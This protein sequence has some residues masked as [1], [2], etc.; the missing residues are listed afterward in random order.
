MFAVVRQYTS[1]IVTCRTRPW[2]PSILK[3]WMSLQ[4]V[5]PIRKKLIKQFAEAIPNLPDSITYGTFTLSQSKH[6]TT[7]ALAHRIPSWPIIG[8]HLKANRRGPAFS[9][10][11]WLLIGRL[12]LRN[13]ATVDPKLA[14]RIIT[15]RLIRPG[16]R[17]G[18]AKVKSNR[19]L[20][21]GARVRCQ[22]QWNR[23]TS[24]V[25][26]SSRDSNKLMARRSWRIK[27]RV[28]LI[29]S[30]RIVKVRIFRYHFETKAWSFSGW[31]SNM[32][33][34]ACDWSGLEYLNDQ[35]VIG[36]GSDWQCMLVYLN[37]Y[38]WQFSMGN[39]W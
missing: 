27:A 14:W 31:P 33:L 17:D 32:W 15:T 2:G 37:V 26:L 5:C 34:W 12:L 21:Q 25:H 24:I 11:W 28:C 8:G 36:Q 22:N 29:I 23:K 7:P 3:L 16:S 13:S 9:L 39:G 1:S 30:R 6:P 4:R 19:N 38:R 10:P 18:L 20:N 35:S